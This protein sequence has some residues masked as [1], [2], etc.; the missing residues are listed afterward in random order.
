M[1]G[2]SRSGPFFL[3]SETEAPRLRLWRRRHVDNQS[4]R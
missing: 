2:P 1:N 3:F 4:E